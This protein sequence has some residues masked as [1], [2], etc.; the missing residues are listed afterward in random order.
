MTHYHIIGIA[1][2]GMSA[3]ANLLLDQ[4]HIVHGS[5]L[6]RNTLT[7]A[8]AARGATI[9][10][11]HDPASIGAAD[12]LIM[13]SAVRP[14]QPE[15][16]AARARGIPI[17]KR[18][19]LWRAWSSQR[20]VVAVAG[21][22]GK[23]TTTALI[24]LA[25][26]HAGLNPGFLVGGEVPD[27]GSNGRWGD[28]AAPLVI[29]ADEYDRT[30]LALTPAIA[31]ITNVEWD[32]V[33]I[34][35]SPE[36]YAAAFR[37]FAASVA[38]PRHLIVCGDDAGAQRAID[39][40]DSVQ[41]GIDEQLARD[42]VSC[43]RA[44]LDWSA[45]KLRVD[46][47]ITRFEVWHYDQATLAN[48]RMGD[49][50]IQ[51]PGAHNVRN[52]LAA[53]VA[54]RAAGAPLSA[55][56]EALA[57]YRG[58]GRR[59]ELKGQAGGV[60]V[61]DDYAHHPTEVRVNLAAARSRYPGRR[62]VAYFQPHTYSRTQALLDEWASAF[63]DAD[64]VRV[65]AIYAAR[66]TDTLGIDDAVVARRLDHAD[67]RAVGSLDQAVDALLDL[68]RPD[69]VLLTL[70]AGDSYKVGEMLLSALA[71]HATSAEDVRVRVT[72]SG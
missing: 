18:A 14:D 16:A 9:F 27:L 49:W 15:V 6:Q 67:A 41:Y 65:G 33:D 26:S 60:T 31:V 24:T 70:G 52:A 30:F 7:A 62:L 23:T 61:I 1:G 55:I 19:D 10:Q 4:G 51:L 11:G 32:H 28:P 68:L 72:D 5:D 17:L 29:E 56:A 64:V 21:T 53:L 44:L 48:R 38:R 34:Y 12:A 50:Q 46:G 57:T 43:R 22:H 47:G 35:P 37:T 13:T 59:F 20:T 42:P 66:E 36:E 58:A 69:D 71:Q 54:A 63:D 25:L 40:P 3:I 45:A 2:A 8:L 39:R